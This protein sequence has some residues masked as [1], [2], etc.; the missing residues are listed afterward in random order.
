MYIIQNG[1][2]SGKVY[3]L[4]VLVREVISLSVACSDCV[5]CF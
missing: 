3:L 2:M 4:W 5:K 1:V